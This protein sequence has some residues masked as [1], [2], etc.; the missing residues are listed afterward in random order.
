MPPTC[1]NTTATRA[2]LVVGII[3]FVAVISGYAIH[4]SRK[5]IVTAQPQPATHNSPIDMTAH[6]A[7]TVSVSSKQGGGG[8]IE[9]SEYPGENSAKGQEDR[10]ERGGQG[11]A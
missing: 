11:K 2:G 5:R 3:A 7:F 4:L 9:L 1:N 6:V 8:E 10:N